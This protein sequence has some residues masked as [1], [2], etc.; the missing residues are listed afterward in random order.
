MTILEI[1]GHALD[2][3]NKEITLLNQCGVGA[4]EIENKLLRLRLQSVFL[5]GMNL[6]ITETTK[7][8]RGGEIDA[9]SQRPISRAS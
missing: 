7:A 3:A 9:K 5:A 4:N 6:G 1:E 2:E 8:M